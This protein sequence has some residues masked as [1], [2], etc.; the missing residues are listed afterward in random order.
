MTLQY[1]Y[2]SLKAICE[3]ACT[4]NEELRKRLNTNPTEASA[5]FITLTIEEIG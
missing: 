1:H 4:E 5:G 2:N 3:L